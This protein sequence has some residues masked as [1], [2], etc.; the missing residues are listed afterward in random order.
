MPNEV[1]E[2]MEWF[3]ALSLT[4]RIQL[5][6]LWENGEESELQNESG[7]YYE[8]FIKMM[9]EIREELLEQS[10][11]EVQES[12]ESQGFD[13]LVSRAI[14]QAVEVPESLQGD[15]IFFQTRRDPDEI[16]ELVNYATDVYLGNRSPNELQEKTFT[17]ENNESEE[18]ELFKRIYR[19]VQEAVRISIEESGGIETLRSEI[20]DET[21][22]EMTEAIF[23]PIKSKLNKLQRYY[24]YLHITKI[25]DRVDNLQEQNGAILQLLQHMCNELDI[26]MDL[27]QETD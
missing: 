4:D 24:I 21:N 11:S 7:D 27:K 14:L 10:E 3:Q 6:E 12:L 15:L 19:F 22:E 20:R 9:H 17:E 5:I 13:E 1:D 18:E 8:G 2:A 23:D 26:D 16:R 25:E